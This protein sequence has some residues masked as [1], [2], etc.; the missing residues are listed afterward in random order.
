MT[1]TQHLLYRYPSLKAYDVIPLGSV[2]MMVGDD[3]LYQYDYSN[4]ADIH[5]ISHIE[6]IGNGQ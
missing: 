5:Q 6:A 1:I 4:P 3:G 2:L